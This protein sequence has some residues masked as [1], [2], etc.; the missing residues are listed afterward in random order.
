[1]LDSIAIKH[2]VL[3]ITTGTCRALK[4]RQF[5]FWKILEQNVFGGGN[6]YSTLKINPTDTNLIFISFFSVV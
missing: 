5:S 4:G 3:I 6:L 2:K 1:M